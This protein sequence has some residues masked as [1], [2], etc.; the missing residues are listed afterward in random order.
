MITTEDITE[1]VNCNICF[2]YGNGYIDCLLPEGL[3]TITS[4]FLTNIMITERDN[5]KNQINLRFNLFKIKEP[6]EISNKGSLKINILIHEKISTQI[7]NYHYY[8]YTTKTRIVGSIMREDIIEKYEEKKFISESKYLDLIKNKNSDKTSDEENDEESYQIHPYIT[9]KKIR[10]DDYID[11]PGKILFNADVIL[12][13]Q[14]MRKLFI[15]YEIPRNIL[16]L[17]SVKA[18]YLFNIVLNNYYLCNKSGDI[19]CINKNEIQTFNKNEIQTFNS[20]LLPSCRHLKN[21]IN[22]LCCLQIEQ[23]YLN[24]DQIDNDIEFI[25]ITY[26]HRNYYNYIDGHKVPLFFT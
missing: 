7:S 23:I 6:Y 25:Q 4:P 17:V 2:P 8:S 1:I 20:Y 10:Q 21:Q 22:V 12:H 26:I 18:N 9:V 5:K 3:Y 24:F 14:L 15:K 19:I 11:K 16:D 13:Y